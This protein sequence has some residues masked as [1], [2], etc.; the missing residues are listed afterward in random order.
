M[1]YNVRR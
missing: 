1:T